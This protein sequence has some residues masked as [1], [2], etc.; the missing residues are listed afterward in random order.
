[1]Y[2]FISLHNT[3]CDDLQPLIKSNAEIMFTKADTV[4]LVCA[5]I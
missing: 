4:L 3:I 5:S 1:M 2:V